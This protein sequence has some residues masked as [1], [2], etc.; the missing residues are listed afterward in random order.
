MTNPSFEDV[1]VPGSP[2]YWKLLGGVGL[3]T[4]IGSPVCPYHVD[5]GNPFHGKVAF[6]VTA[7]PDGARN[8]SAQLQPLN[9]Q[10]TAYVMSAYM[11]AERD[12]MQARFDTSGRNA[13]R[14]RETFTLTTDWKRYS[15]KVIVPDRFIMRY[16]FTIAVPG[17]KA[18][19]V[20]IDAV[21]LERGEEATEFQP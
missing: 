20:W 19:A 15:M 11:K 8:M 17:Q 5:T 21:Q 6:R 7:G 9:P 18:G 2:D 1:T 12:G 4:R 13:E 10:P 14:T 3:T 16:G